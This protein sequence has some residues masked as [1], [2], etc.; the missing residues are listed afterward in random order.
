MKLT[1][2]DELT[3]KIIGKQGTAERDSFD[4]NLRMDIIGTII[5][6]AISNAIFINSNSTKLNIGNRNDINLVR[7][8]DICIFVQNLKYEF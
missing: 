8:L 2:I 4:Y 7:Q 3:D 5:R 1:T 6:D